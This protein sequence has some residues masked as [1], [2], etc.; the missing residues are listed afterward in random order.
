MP[1][2]L[3]AMYTAGVVQLPSVLTLYTA[4]NSLRAAIHCTSICQAQRPDWVRAAV[5][6]SPQVSPSADRRTS[7]AVVAAAHPALP[8]STENIHQSPGARRT[9]LGEMSR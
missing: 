5:T 8:A 4:Q 2:A 7:T 3:D 1:S 9:T 6:G